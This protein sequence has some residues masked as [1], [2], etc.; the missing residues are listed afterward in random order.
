MYCA[1]QRVQSTMSVSVLCHNDGLKYVSIYVNIYIP[2]NTKQKLDGY[3][4]PTRSLYN[5]PASWS[6]WALYIEKY[7]YMPKAIY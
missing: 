7:V 4:R 5:R 1:K 2:N 3:S 6:Q